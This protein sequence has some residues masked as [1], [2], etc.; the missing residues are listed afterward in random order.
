MAFAMYL[1]L[2]IHILRQ[3]RAAVLLRDAAQDFGL[4]FSFL[5]LDTLA[6]PNAHDD[7]RGYRTPFVSVMATKPV[8]FLRACVVVQTNTTFFLER[9]LQTLETGSPMTHTY[10]LGRAIFAPTTQQNLRGR[11]LPMVPFA[12][13]KAIKMIRRNICIAQTSAT[14]CGGDMLQFRQ[15]V[16]LP[17]ALG[18]LDV[19]ALRAPVAIVGDIV[20]MRR[21]PMSVRAQEAVRHQP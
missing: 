1:G 6:A 8:S 2:L 14:F 7:V 17:H 15:S 20:R 10:F 18:T 5:I 13:F 12:T 16:L 21:P 11:C 9:L 4:L 19:D 3:K